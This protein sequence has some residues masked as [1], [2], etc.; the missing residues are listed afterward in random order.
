[1]RNV[2]SGFTKVY[3][4]PLFGIEI[5]THLI[6]TTIFVKGFCHD[7]DEADFYEIFFDKPT[8]DAATKKWIK[9]AMDEGI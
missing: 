7:E 4:N 5:F 3:E 6:G 1:M 8:A 2:G 9:K